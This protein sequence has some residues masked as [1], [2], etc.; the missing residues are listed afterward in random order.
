MSAI[1]KLLEAQNDLINPVFNAMTERGNED[2][3]VMQLEDA[4]REAAYMVGGIL[5]GVK[6]AIIH[7]MNVIK[8]M[9]LDDVI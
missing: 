3:P 9:D 2:V 7:A 5:I 1:K 6:I 8:E 4:Q